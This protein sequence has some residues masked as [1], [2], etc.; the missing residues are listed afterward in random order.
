MFLELIGVFAAGFAGAGLMLILSR[1][2][3]GRLPRW[4]MPLGA[5]GAMILATASLEYSWYSRTAGNLPTGLTVAQAVPT[6]AFWRPWSYAVP[7]TERFVAVDTAN[8]LAN[9]ETGG[10]YM[11]N[12]YFYD[13]WKG[14]KIVQVMVDCVGHRRADPVLGDGSPPLWRDVGADDPVVKTA[15]AE[16]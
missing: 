13:R 3:G 12:V 16:A 9:A 5:G 1:L 15:C 14:K 10:L 6:S 8:R 7:V 11:V 2:S 4:A